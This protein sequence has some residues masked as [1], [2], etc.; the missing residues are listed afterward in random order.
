MR[1]GRK[2][3]FP[4]AAPA[5]AWN[6]RLLSHHELNGFGGMGEGLSVQLAKDGR[7]IL[8]SAHESAPKNF[9]GV[10]VTDPRAPKV[11]VQ[12]ELPEAFMRS[13]SLELVGDI[14]VVA[15]QT[16][17]PGQTP[18]GFEVFDVSRPESPRSVAF[19]DASGPHF[20][21]AS[22]SSGSAT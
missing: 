7:R 16:K 20:R 21:A 4:Y 18:A 12:T 2:H 1:T 22:T 19:F 13:N 17:N 10:D 3:H 15:Y 9:T 5:A 6:F 8:W 14:M 11:A